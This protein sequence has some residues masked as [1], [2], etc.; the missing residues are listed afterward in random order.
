MQGFMQIGRHLQSEHGEG[1]GER[2]RETARRAACGV[3]RLF[4]DERG[5]G[6]TR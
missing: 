1:L 4:T 6:A 2:D 3:L 5:W